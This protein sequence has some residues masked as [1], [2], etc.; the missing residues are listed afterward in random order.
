VHAGVEVRDRHSAAELEGRRAAVAGLDDKRVIDEVER[1]LEG[2]IA[3]MQPSRREA[4][5]VD[6]ERDVPPVV[7]RRRGRQPDL[8]EYL[9]V[10]MQRV[11]RCAPIAQMELGQCCHRASASINAAAS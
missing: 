4:A 9:A 6:V 8:A 11:F 7:A 2:R 3:V 10:Q 5:D 1:D